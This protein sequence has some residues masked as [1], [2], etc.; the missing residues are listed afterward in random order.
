MKWVGIF[1]VEI[2]W[3]G[4]FWGGIFQGEFDGWEFSRREFPENHSKRKQT[5]ISHESIFYLKNYVAKS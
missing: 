4:I 3:V 5:F 1:Q 2:F